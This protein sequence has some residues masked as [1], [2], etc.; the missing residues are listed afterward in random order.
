MFLW[1]MICH[2]HLIFMKSLSR[3]IGYLR[4]GCRILRL[5]LLC[6]V[7]ILFPRDRKKII[8][9]AWW[10]NQFADNPRYF[11]QY[12]LQLKMGYKCYWVGKSHL[13]DLVDKVPGVTFV[14]K[15]SLSAIWHVL[16]A[17]WFVSNLGVDADITT[18]PTYGKIKF[19]TFW[20]GTI[21]KGPAYG[22]RSVKIE[23]N[24]FH[25]LAMRFYVPEFNVACPLYAYASFS[26]EDMRYSMPKEC[27]WQ[28]KPEWSIA[29]GT[30]RIDYLIQNVGNNVELRRVREKCAKILSIPLDKKWYLYAPTFRK[31]LAVTYTFLDCKDRVLLDEIL[32]RNNAIIIEKQH[33][34]IIEAR[35]IADMKSNTLYIV[36]KVQSRELEMQELLLACDRLITDYSSSF[37][38]FEAMA[39]PVIHF[40]YD[41][42]TYSSDK[43][44]VLYSLHDIAAGPVVKTEKELISA[45][46]M[47]DNEL[48][49][50]KGPKAAERIAGEK[51]NACETFAKWVG[52]I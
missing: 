47:S 27:P 33:P 35:N 42:N 51:G 39:R 9:G 4:L 6:P 1:Q 18:F 2:E 40:A 46:G 48:L 29:A 13:K 30:P 37:F 23:G 16:T 25:R 22:G 36:S 21:I 8:F 17:K 26:N 32:E 10:G 19:L 41:Y 7:V 52:L 49:S 31:G 43:R 11:L 3:C 38:D 50:K 20:H 15:D 44:G 14:R 12:I 45:I 24:F 5:L 34:Q 28:F